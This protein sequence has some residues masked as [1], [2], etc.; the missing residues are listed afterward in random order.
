[1]NLVLPD[2]KIIPHFF[3][4]HTQLSEINSEFEKDV[5]DFVERSKIPYYGMIGYETVPF[6]Y[7]L[8]NIINNS[9][10]NTF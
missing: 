9:A 6:N 8:T 4:I 7:H 3:T 5:V 2:K 10:K 1:M